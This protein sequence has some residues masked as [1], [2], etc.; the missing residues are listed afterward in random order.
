MKTKQIHS[1]DLTL[2][3]LNW[4]LF[5]IKNYANFLHIVLNSDLK[6]TNIGQS[7]IMK[8]TYGIKTD[9]NDNQYTKRMQKLDNPCL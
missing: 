7:T 3:Q 9:K 5:K 1:M 4:C 8:T 2:R 6:K